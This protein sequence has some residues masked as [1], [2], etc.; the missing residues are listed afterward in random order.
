M[1]TRDG[2][3]T[4]LRHAIDQTLAAERLE[5]WRPTDAHVDALTRLARDEVSFDDYLAAYRE[6]HSKASPPARDY[7][8]LFRR[9]RR[10]LI[11]GTTV[12]RNNFGVDSQTALAEL[13]FVATAGRMIAWHRMLADGDIGIDGVNVR[14]IHQHLFADVYPW[15]GNYRVTELRHDDS[16]FVWQSHLARLMALLDETTRALA[17]T[18]A[19]LEPA[20]LA[21]RLARLYADYNHIHPFREGNGRAGALLLHTIAALCGRALDLTEIT[22]DAWYAA[23]RDSMPLRRDGRANHRPFLP[24]L[25]GAVR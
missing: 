19:G 11:P 7:R 14:A 1:I 25:A 20:G 2:L 5:G 3:P 4:P 16:L 8:Q 10:Y 23:S 18:G 15:A 24:L 9:N 13:E 22:R 17:A 6:R 21:Y 12:L